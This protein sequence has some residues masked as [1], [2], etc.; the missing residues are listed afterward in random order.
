M[1][2]PAAFGVMMADAHR[3]ARTRLEASRTDHLADFAIIVVGASSGGVEALSRLAS[4][5]PRDIPAA[6]LVVQHIGR[7]PS[8]LPEL[9]S[10]S[11]SLSAVHARHGEVLRP[12]RIY[13]APP[14]HHLLLFKGFIMRLSRGPRENWARPAID[15]MLRT[16]AE[17]YG[18]RVAGVILTGY[19]ND[20]TA[21][22][23]DVKRRGGRSAVPRLPVAA[24]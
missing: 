20:G 15:P 1:A 9:L 11:G 7:N 14:D 19:L 24:H 18:P 2:L 5:L 6:M 8:R 13:V 16:A 12:G 17:T 23:L 3:L 10:R 4:G 21:G 22:L